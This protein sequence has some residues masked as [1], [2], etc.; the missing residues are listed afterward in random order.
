MLNIEFKTYEKTIPELHGER[1]VATQSV[2]EDTGDILTRTFFKYEF[3]PLIYTKREE[4][5]PPYWTGILP[6]DPSTYTN[7]IEL[8]HHF[9]VKQEYTIKEYTGHLMYG[10]PIE[11]EGSLEGQYE[12]REG[13]INPSRI[14]L[15]RGWFNRDTELASYDYYI[16]IRTGQEFRWESANYNLTIPRA[17]ANRANA[18]RGGVS[19]NNGTNSNNEEH[20]QLVTAKTQELESQGYTTKLLRNDSL[21]T[22]I[23]AKKEIFNTGGIADISWTLSTNE[24]VFKFNSI[25]DVGLAFNLTYYNCKIWLSKDGI[26]KT[27]LIADHKAPVSTIQEDTIDGGSFL[28]PIIIPSSTIEM[29]E[30]DLELYVERTHPYLIVKP[31]IKMTNNNVDPYW[32]PVYLD[33]K[34]GDK[35]TIILEFIGKFYYNYKN[36]IID[37]QVEPT[38]LEYP[39]NEDPDLNDPRPYNVD[40]GYYNF[41]SEDDDPDN[42]G[43]MTRG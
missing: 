2:K 41:Q 15:Y 12:L 37:I 3:K 5:A 23:N 9:K 16:P 13:E 36:D 42:W 31:Y 38:L 28:G 6:D 33:T 21:A 30:P 43:I 34:I 27:Q 1:V 35:T 10:L 22:V 7:P 25:K 19:I 24:I 11:N 18:N 20:N 17:N 14:N 26:K 8:D 4:G 32:P 29:P 39:T 40:V